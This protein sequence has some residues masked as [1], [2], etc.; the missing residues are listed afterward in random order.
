MLLLLLT[1]EMVYPST[2]E[3]SEKPDNYMLKEVTITGSTNINHF[4]LSYSENHFSAIQ[5]NGQPQNKFSVNIPA[6]KIGA[7]SKAML[8]DFLKMIN[9][10]KYPDI[11]ITL[12]EDI[13][14]EM[15]ATAAADHQIGL[16]LNGKTNTYICHSTSTEYNQD[17]W[18]L[19][20]RLQFKL[21]DFGIDPP[22]KIFGIVKVEDAVFINFKIVFTND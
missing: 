2:P 22:K 9:A 13:S 16:T 19:V 6:R 15:D 1:G 8:N 4:Q 3:D 17:Q 5:E 10:Y 12:D 20:G 7:G 21:S 14:K 11:K 18:C